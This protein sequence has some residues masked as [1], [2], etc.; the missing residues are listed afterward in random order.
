MTGGQ[1]EH[2]GVEEQLL[3]IEPRRHAPGRVLPSSRRTELGLILS[4]VEPVVTVAL[5]TLVFAERLGAGQLVGGALVLAAVLVLRTTG[6]G[7]ALRAAGL[8]RP[9]P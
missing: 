8:V 5:A 1:H 4:T 2:H 3:A 7:P 9:A 6:A